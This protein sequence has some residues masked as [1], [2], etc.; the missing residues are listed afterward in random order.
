MEALLPALAIRGH[1][2]HPVGRE[3]LVADR[4][5]QV[6]SA[7]AKFGSF[8]RAAQYLY[9]TQPAVTF[10]VK[11]LEEHFNARLLERG[12]NGVT[13]TEAGQ[14]VL[15]YAGRILE[16]SQELE[17]RMA[18]LSAAPGGV[19]TLAVSTTIAACWMPH[20]L[21]GFCA[22]YPDVVPQ[23]VVG[24]SLRM[25]KHVSEREADFGMIEI[26]P[27][28]PAL[29]CE[30]V[31]RDELYAVLP[32]AHPLAAEPSLTAAQLQALPWVSQDAGN[33]IRTLAE[34]FFTQAGIDPASLHVCAQLGS[35]ESVLHLVA[36]GQGFAIAPGAALARLGA[37]GTLVWVPL[38]PQLHTPLYLILPKD[39]Y[40]TRLA[41]AFVEHVRQNAPDIE[42]ENARLLR[43]AMRQG[44]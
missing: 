9:M 21:E 39:K 23:M 38:V 40:R 14:V 16:L 1:G 29:D 15:E 17:A 43:G 22:R 32:Q 7:V 2:N 5:L 12:H 42:Q 25:S 34:E 36:C 30:E 3:R 31:A 27:Q 20:L 44:E 28:H 26:C 33:A 19:L 10:Q 6:F 8:T 35:L 24:S 18:E 11:Q 37:G 41:A 13:I 4:R